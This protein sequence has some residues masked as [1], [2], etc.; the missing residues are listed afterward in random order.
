MARLVNAAVIARPPPWAV[1]PEGFG[2][3]PLSP[4]K[5]PYAATVDAAVGTAGLPPLAGNHCQPPQC[6][7]A[8]ESSALRSDRRADHVIGMID[9][10]ADHVI[11]MIDRRADQIDR[12]FA[13]NES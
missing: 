13:L 2:L 10:R 11:G 7:A 6:F 5:P 9:R 8:L 4:L 1:K 3:S 12:H